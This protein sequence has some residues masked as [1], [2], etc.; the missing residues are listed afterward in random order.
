LSHDLHLVARRGAPLDAERL[1]AVL[2][3]QRHWRLVEGS[4][5][6]WWYENP[7]TGVY[8]SLDPD[9]NAV[10]NYVRPSFFG[11]EFLA[12]IVEI[13]GALDF[14]VVDPQ[15][16]EI[17]GPATPKAAVFDEL[18]ATWEAGNAKSAALVGGPGTRLPT[19]GRPEALEWWTYMRARAGYQM[20][21]GESVFAPELRLVR[22]WETDRV[23]RLITWVEGNPALFPACDLVALLRPHPEKQFQIHG[24]VDRGALARALAPHL[25]QKRFDDLPAQPSLDPEH[26]DPSRRAAASL[27]VEPFAGFDPVKR[28]EFLDL[29]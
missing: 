14:L 5:R 23:L 26:A 24:V 7:D 10:L 22:R 13:A 2:A 11:R 25:V 17:A 28:D 15:D 1:A 21:L 6:Q 16:D 4:A 3:K 27:S 9:M 29:S 20:R 19:M 18:F 8:G 12:L